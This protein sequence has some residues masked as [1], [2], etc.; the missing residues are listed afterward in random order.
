[1][2]NFIKQKWT[3][4]LLLA[5]LAGGNKAQAQQDK[6]FSQYM[7]NMMALNP[8]Y[9]GSRD[10]LSATALYRNQWGGLEGAPQTATFT[11]D[12]PVNR[13]RVG[14][15][16]QLF[17][18]R[19]GLENWTGAMLSYA[20]RIKLGERSTLAL[21]LQGGAA[22]FRWDLTSANLGSSQSDPAFSSSI[23]KILPNFGT[24]IYLSNDR[25]YLGISVPYLIESNLNSGDVSS[26]Q[27]AKIRRH[28]Y[29]MMGFV[30]GRNNI[31]LKPS[32]LVK[33]VNGAPLALDG[34]LNLWFS[35][36]IAFGVSYRNN[37]FNTYAG[38][39]QAAPNGDVLTSDA[40][41]GMIELQL[42]DQF[43]FGYS[44]DWTQ[45]GLNSNR[46]FL[47]IPTHEIMLRYEFGFTKSKILTPR[48]F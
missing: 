42:S 33:Y 15:G 28:F 1:M 12:M 24:G 5:L 20:F 40:L 13:E 7:F 2:Q 17:N 19:V 29:G 41:V 9:A 46:Q 8:A 21:G 39:I 10:V 43:R 14:V 22:S 48:Y 45:N 36:R 38:Q 44:Y 11:L 6:M 34:N 30:I 27:R 47:N 18:D 35:D 31:K 4:L 16:I 26:V 23:S 25:S 37:R 32:M 3:L